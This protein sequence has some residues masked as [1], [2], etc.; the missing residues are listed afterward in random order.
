L[1]DIQPRRLREQKASEV[2]QVS[3]K[4]HIQ[5]TKATTIVLFPTNESVNV[6]SNQYEVNETMNE[7]VV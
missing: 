3:E 2:T 7:Y 4:K 1:L 5:S 6:R